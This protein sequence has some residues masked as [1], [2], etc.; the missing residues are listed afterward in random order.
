MPICGRI[1]NKKLPRGGDAL[2]YLKRRHATWIR[3]S[4]FQV[5][6]PREYS[7]HLRCALGRPDFLKNLRL[8]FFLDSTLHFWS[9]EPLKM[10]KG[11]FLPKSPELWSRRFGG[12]TYRPLI[13][14]SPGD[15]GKKHPWV[16]LRGSLLQNWR[17]EAKKKWAANFS[18]YRAGL[19]RNL[20]L[21]M[22]QLKILLVI[23][24]NSLFL[25]SNTTIT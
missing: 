20:H 22:D 13:F 8:T 9:M 3:N 24:M 18:K 17:V 21:K 2:V 5:Y 12:F 6:K 10:T 23:T 14:P 16:I 15:L 4:K 19:M 1:M 7:L 11:C 25:R